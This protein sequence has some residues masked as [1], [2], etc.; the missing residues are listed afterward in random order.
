MSEYGV[1]FDMDGVLVDSNS[2]H[3]ESIQKFCIKYNRPFSDEYF[4]EQICGRPNGEWIPDVFDQL[5]D[6]EI[7]QLAEEKE[8]IF[9]AIF[10]PESSVIS[11]LFDF[12]DLLKDQQIRIAVATSA[13]RENADYILSELSINHYFDA[14]LNSSHIENGKPHPEIYLKAAEAIRFP[15]AKCVIFEDSLVGVKAGIES[16]AKVIGVTSTHSPEEMSSCNRV[17]ADF[18]GL[19]PG[20]LEKLIKS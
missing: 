20:M 8:R 18:T 11:G 4:R 10:N 6:Q 16:G 1:I 17:I 15:P 14:V 19:S 9:R 5:T 2:A 7:F 13:T 12:L 3:R